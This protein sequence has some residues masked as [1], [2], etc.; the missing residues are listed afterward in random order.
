M[1]LRLPLISVKYRYYFILAWNWKVTYWDDI[2]LHDT[3]CWYVWYLKDIV[4]F[5]EL[6]CLT[7]LPLRWN[8]PTFFLF[9]CLRPLKVLCSRFFRLIPSGLNMEVCGQWELI[10]SRFKDI[11]KRFFVCYAN[12]LFCFIVFHLLSELCCLRVDYHYAVWSKKLQVAKYCRIL[13]SL[14]NCIFDSKY[15]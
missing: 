7:K 8:Y 5:I 3:F 15:P 4:I 1:P 14:W 12:A 6:N 13:H 11:I 9:L 2:P 10:Q